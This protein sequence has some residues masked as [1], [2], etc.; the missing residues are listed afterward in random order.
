V[1]GADLDLLGV[2]GLESAEDIALQPRPHCGIHDGGAG[3]RRDREP[4]YHGPHLP[5]RRCCRRSPAVP[6]PCPHHRPLNPS[7]GSTYPPLNPNSAEPRLLT[8]LVSIIVGASLD[9]PA[10]AL[11]CRALGELALRP[12]S[13]S[14]GQRRLAVTRPSCATKWSA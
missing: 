13:P 10:S 3:E 12:R 11:N 6:A 8:T 1:A 7:P 14:A 5:R 2:P 4:H 9:P